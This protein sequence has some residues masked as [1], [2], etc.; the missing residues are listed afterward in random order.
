[1]RKVCCR[2]GVRLVGP[3]AEFCRE[4]AHGTLCG[5]VEVVRLE[6]LPRPPLD[7]HLGMPAAIADRV[8]TELQ[9]HLATVE[10]A[11]LVAEEAMLAGGGEQE[12]DVPSSR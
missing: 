11:R 9:W 8:A 3:A 10:D 1:M 2:I 12:R 5:K 7:P 6:L 4:P